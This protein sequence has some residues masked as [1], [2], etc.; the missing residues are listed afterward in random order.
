MESSIYEHIFKELYVGLKVNLGCGDDIVLGYDNIDINP[1]SPTVTKMDFS[2]L[3]YADNSVEE[4]RANNIIQHIPIQFFD[5]IIRHWHSKLHPGGELSISSPNIDTLVNAIMTS[6]IKL[7]EFNFYLY[8]S[9]CGVPY[10]S[11]YSLDYVV[12]A[13]ESVG[14]VVTSKSHWGYSFLVKATKS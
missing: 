2:N 5:Q 13:L 8:S 1:K 7:D 4:L 10:L 6:Q 14:F 11:T 3:S 12:N 9:Q